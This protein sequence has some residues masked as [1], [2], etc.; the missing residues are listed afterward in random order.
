TEKATNSSVVIMDPN[1][2]N[3]RRIFDSDTS[4][5]DPAQVQRGMAGAFQPA[6]SPDGQWV[7]FG[8]GEWFQ[9][10]RTGKA[11]IM[12]I[13]RDGTGLEALTDGTIHSGF[14]SYSADGNE[15]VYRVFGEAVAGLRMLNIKTRKSRV[16]TTEYDNLPQWS[17]DGTRIVF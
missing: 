2:S 15:I 6:W 17:P 14:P 16:L 10:R 12:R 8:L 7:T 9:M 1:G 11:R 3:R 5:L 4:D 13:R